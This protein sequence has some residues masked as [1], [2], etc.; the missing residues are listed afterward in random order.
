MYTRYIV[1]VMILSVFGGMSSSCGS[2]GLAQA[3][4][5]VWLLNQLKN[6]DRYSYTGA[7]KMS[8]LFSKRIMKDIR[9]ATTDN[10]ADSMAADTGKLTLYFDGGSRGNPGHAGGGVLLKYRPPLSPSVTM[11]TPTSSTMTGLTASTGATTGTAD[12]TVWKGSFYFGKNIT[13]NAAEYSA[14]L[15]GLRKVADLVL[16]SSSSTIPA[17]FKQQLEIKGDSLLVINQLKEE[18]QVRSPN[19]QGLHASCKKLLD[20]SVL[21]YTLIHIDRE[22]NSEADALAN[23]AIDEREDSFEFDD[24]SFDQIVAR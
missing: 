6:S 22:Y 4:S 13:N 3:F 17:P 2:R 18:Y 1:G 9:F 23:K 12:T 5:P 15:A 11:S 8:R 16:N 14:L 19:L 10:N 7:Y 21:N 24:V 20:E